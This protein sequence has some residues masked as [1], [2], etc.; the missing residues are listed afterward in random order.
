MYIDTSTKT[1][2]HSVEIKQQNCRHIIILMTMIFNKVVV[3]NIFGGMSDHI[4]VPITVQCRNFNISECT[5]VVKQPY[6]RQ[7]A[8]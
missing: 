7:E 4:F 6:H 2:V 1:S 8:L 3:T 5:S